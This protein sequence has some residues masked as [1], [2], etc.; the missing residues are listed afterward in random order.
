MEPLALSDELRIL[1][2]Y[3]ETYSTLQQKK[4]QFYETAKATFFSSG[5]TTAERVESVAEGLHLLEGQRQLGIRL[6][7]GH[8][9]TTTFLVELHVLIQGLQVAAEHELLQLESNID[10]TEAIHM[11][12]HGYNNSIWEL[13]CQQIYSGNRIGGGTC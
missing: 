5:E 9:H 10:S 1:K 3:V 7:E 11:L 2:M 4:V 8:S 6:H 13:Q 12:T